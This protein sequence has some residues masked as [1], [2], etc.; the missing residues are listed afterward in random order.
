MV[1]KNQRPDIIHLFWG[2]Y[3]SLIGYLIKKYMS[4]IPVSMFLGAYDL[5]W[6][7]GCTAPVAREADVVW[8]HCKA[9]VPDIL[10]LGVKPKNLIV[11]YRGVD[12]SKLK[13][14]ASK[15]RIK[16]RIVSVGT[17]DES[18]NM[19][20]VL[21]IFQKIKIKWPEA[22]LVILGDGPERSNL[23]KY[24]NDLGINHSVSFRGYVTHDEVF[25]TLSS[26][27]VF[28]FMSK[29][30]SERLPNVVKE[31]MSTGCLCVVTRTVGIEE[32]ITNWKNGF[33]VDIDDCETVYNIISMVF[34]SE[35][36]FE[37]ICQEAERNIKINFD[38]NVNMKAYIDKWKEITTTIK[39]GYDN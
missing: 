13:R 21:K 16:Y 22:S 17:L 9:N 7:Y 14:N 2:H 3:P 8:T 20:L 4:D 31:A 32:L 27:E 35:K 38:V 34:R 30:S 15:K 24:S 12:I 23:I 39:R 19:H 28:M 37:K 25:S 11:S 10:S 6:N 1:I 33:T 36:S 18:K 29:K 26:A 5:V